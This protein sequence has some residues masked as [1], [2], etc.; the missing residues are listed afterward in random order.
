VVLSHEILV[1]NNNN[2]N[3][4]IKRTTKDLHIML[5][6]DNDLLYCL[7]QIIIFDRIQL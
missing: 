1:D 2:D 6:K 3:N 4:F 7:F 5:Y